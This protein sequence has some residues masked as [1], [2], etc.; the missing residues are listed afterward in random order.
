[1]DDHVSIVR[2]ATTRGAQ[3]LDFILEEENKRSK[4][5]LHPRATQEDW[6]KTYRN[7]DSLD[8]MRT[9][10]FAGLG[11]QDPSK[12]ASRERKSFS[13]EV[14][15]SRIFLRGSGFFAADHTVLINF[16]ME[17]IS[18]EIGDVMEDAKQQLRE[19]SREIAQFDEVDVEADED[20]SEDESDDDFEF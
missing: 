1:M 7:L 13:T 15:K 16:Q 4:K 6:I 9:A 17:E 20:L 8:R 19:Q 12:A 2:G 18:R 10:A 11:A 5:Y 3:G 14:Q